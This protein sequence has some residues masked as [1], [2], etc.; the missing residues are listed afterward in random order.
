M[1]HPH[2]PVRIALQILF[3]FS[4][5]ITT[6]Y[7]LDACGLDTLADYNEFLTSQQETVILGHTF[8]AE[9]FAI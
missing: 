2:S 8:S 9:Q 3:S 4:I 1:C 7:I 5:F 6:E